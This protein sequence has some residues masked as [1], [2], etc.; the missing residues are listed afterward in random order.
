M[1]GL[2]QARPTLH[3]SMM[4]LDRAPDPD[5]ANARKS[6]HT[7]NQLIGSCVLIARPF[8]DIIRRVAWSPRDRPS[9]ARINPSCTPNVGW[10]ESRARPSILKM[11][12]LKQGSPPLTSVAGTKPF[13]KRTQPLATERTQLPATERTQHSFPRSSVGMPSSTLRVVLSGSTCQLAEDAECPDDPPIWSA[14]ACSRSG[15]RSLLRARVTWPTSS[16]PRPWSKLHE[17]KREQALAL[18]RREDEPV[19]APT[20]KSGYTRVGRVTFLRNRQCLLA[21]RYGLD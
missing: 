12:G 18:Q 3:F 1:V 17:A 21:G 6:G 10:I 8:R 20:R 19:R 13:R 14:R 7:L 9:S 5:L 16:G 15:D 4:R 2:A 11:G